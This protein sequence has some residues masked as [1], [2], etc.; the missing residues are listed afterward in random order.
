MYMSPFLYLSIL[1]IHYLDLSFQNTYV[2]PSLYFSPLYFTPHLCCMY[3][4][5]NNEHT[6]HLMLPYIF[7]T[8]FVML[9]PWSPNICHCVTVNQCRYQ[10]PCPVCMFWLQEVPYPSEDE[11]QSKL[12]QYMN[13]NAYRNN[14]FF[15]TLYDSRDHKTDRVQVTKSIVNRWRLGFKHVLIIFADRAFSVLW[16]KTLEW[17][18]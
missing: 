9:S 11:L 14:T 2:K 18:S 10:C 4:K 17:T 6:I 3:V 15:S 7:V 12:Q 1:Y 8:I 16:T 13:W 5:H